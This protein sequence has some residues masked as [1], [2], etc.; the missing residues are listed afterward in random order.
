M[1]ETIT[2]PS[3]RSVRQRA[4]LT[5]SRARVASPGSSGMNR[6]SSAPERNARFISTGARAEHGEQRRTR[7]MLR[8]ALEKAQRSLLVTVDHHQGRVRRRGG[9]FREIGGG[10]SLTLDCLEFRLSERRQD[11]ND[12]GPL[13]TGIAD[14]HDLHRAATALTL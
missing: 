1:T 9:I 5:F 13:F 2:P 12:L 14:Q 11:G 4:S 3:R 7:R 8:L 10:S 6:I